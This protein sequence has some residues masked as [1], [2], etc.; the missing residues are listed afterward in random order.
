MRFVPSMANSATCVCDKS[1]QQAGV[2]SAALRTPSTALDIDLHVAENE[3]LGWLELLGPPLG[4]EEPVVES[5]SP[6][7]LVTAL[8]EDLV[9]MQWPAARGWLLRNVALQQLLHVRCG[10]YE[11]CF[12]R[13]ST[14]A[15]S[16]GATRRILRQ[17]VCLVRKHTATP[18]PRLIEGSEKA[19]S[20]TANPSG[21]AMPGRSSRSYQHVMAGSISEAKMSANPATASWSSQKGPEMGTCREEGSTVNPIREDASTVG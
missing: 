8:M 20:A 19:S 9:D 13:S 3:A 4:R 6:R 14:G 12:R 17:H 10:C 11:V 15:L 1:V 16:G 7:L 18:R 21:H 2:A 5:D